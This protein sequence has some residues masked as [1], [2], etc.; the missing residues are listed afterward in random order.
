MDYSRMINYSYTHRGMQYKTFLSECKKIVLEN[1]LKGYSLKCLHK[2]QTKKFSLYCD[3]LKNF[4]KIQRMIL[5]GDCKTKQ[6]LPTRILVREIL[7]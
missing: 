1:S 4:G 3:G 7:V 2:D 6:G 5:T